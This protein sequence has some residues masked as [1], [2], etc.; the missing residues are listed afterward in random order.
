MLFSAQLLHFGTTVLRVDRDPQ[1]GAVKHA[2]CFLRVDKANNMLQWTRPS[3]STTGLAQALHSNLSSSNSFVSS[4]S[5][6]SAVYGAPRGSAASPM[7]LPHGHLLSATSM[8]EAIESMIYTRHCLGLESA[9]D[10]YDEGFIEFAVLKEMRFGPGLFSSALDTCDANDLFNMFKRMNFEKEKLTHDAFLTVVYGCSF[11]T[12]HT[13]TFLFPPH[14]ARIWNYA[15][16]KLMRGLQLQ[17]RLVDHRMAWL[18]QQYV[19][20]FYTYRALPCAA[21]VVRIFGGRRWSLTGV[22]FG[23]PAYSNHPSH[24]GKRG[25]STPPTQRGT[26]TSAHHCTVHT[27]HLYL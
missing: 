25:R 2:L 26:C 11:S 15:I 13:V 12:F 21:N 23:P 10:G 9:Y 19:R 14:I 16:T 8:S 5:A 20:L 27:V 1:S 24:S 6:G 7:S 22:T 3:W 18:K 4:S 17:R